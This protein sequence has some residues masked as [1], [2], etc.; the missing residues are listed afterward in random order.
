MN[1]ISTLEIVL[2]FNNIF[3]IITLIIFRQE[4]KVQKKKQLELIELMTL[5]KVDKYEAYKDIHGL[6]T[7]KKG[8]G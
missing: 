6:Y 7:N 1:K 2:L 4:L 3:N 5:N 8:G